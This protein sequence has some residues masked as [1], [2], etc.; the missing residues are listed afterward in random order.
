MQLKTLIL[1]LIGLSFVSACRPVT[2]AAL[3]SD[4]AKR[5]PDVQVATA[6]AVAADRPFAD[7]VL[8]MDRACDQFGCPE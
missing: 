1:M 6:R 7:W 2:D 4:V 8:Y 5:P 3:W